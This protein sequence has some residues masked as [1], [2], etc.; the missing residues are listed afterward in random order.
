MDVVHV[1]DSLASSGGAE[2][3][4]VDEIEALA[5]RDGLDQTV[6]RLYARDAL[7]PRLEAAGVPVLALGYDARHAGRTW[8]LAARR[9][10]AILRQR[11]PAVVHTSLF[12]ANLVGQLAARPL[13]IPVV[14]S[15]NRTGDLGLQRSLQP[16]V[17]GW[18]GRTMQ[19]VA[20]TVARGG[21]VWYRAVSAYA[22]D[23]NC[24][25]MGFPPEQVTVVPRGIDLGA[26]PGPADRAA[27]GLPD[28]VPLVVNVARLVPEKAQH[29]LVEAF[30]AA[31]RDL[32][33]AV[34]AI[35]GSPG[36]AEPEV[37][38]AVAR[39][40]LG[41]AVRLLG[42][43]DDARALVAAADVFAFSSLSEG[44][45][46][47]VLEALALGTPVAAFDIPPVAE[48][49]GGGRHAH[50]VPVGDVDKLGAAIVAAARSPRSTAGREWAARFDLAAVADQLAA[51]LSSRA[52]AR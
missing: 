19:A 13:R 26:L 45:P 24:A 6:V 22:R 10:W 27:F 28:G 34:L 2:N 33:D 7:Q 1:V 47:A 37:R 5:A 15:F 46:G 32:P 41:D 18:R 36:P 8:P 51:L 49:T 12:S 23:T 35:V 9:L 48:L 3:R 42:F 52:A 29:L 20:R 50:L 4:L 39:H 17:A 40:G 44:S 25:L 11:R 16:G 21:D 43:R 30:A 38:A 14:S 31:R